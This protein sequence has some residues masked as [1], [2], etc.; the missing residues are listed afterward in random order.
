MKEMKTLTINNKSYVITDSGAI[1]FD[2]EQSLTIEQQAQARE[3]IG[4]AGIGEGGVVDAGAV[5]YTEQ[6]L[7]ESQQAQARKNIGAASY[8]DVSP[9]A[10][11][12]QVRQAVAVVDGSFIRFDDVF[13]AVENSE[14]SV[15]GQCK[16]IYGLEAHT[17]TS[18]T[19][20]V[21]KSV[22]GEHWTEHASLSI[23]ASNGVW[24]TNLFVDTFKN[25]LILLKTTDG[26]DMK[27]N[28]VCT[29]VYNGTSWYNNPANDVALG[30]KRWLSNNCS[31]DAA[32]NADWSERA[33][34]FGEYGTTED[35]TTYSLWKITIPNITNGTGWKKVLELGGNKDN[36]GFTGEIRHWHTVRFDPYSKHW[37]A[38][39]GD[40]DSQCRMYR[41]TDHG[42]TWDL[43]FSGSQ[44]ERTTGFVFEQDCIYYGMDSTNNTDL[45]S[46]KI[47]KIDRSKL[48]TD[49]ENCRTDVATVDSAFAIRGLSRTY[50]PDGFIVFTMQEPNAS[51]T[52]GRYILQFFD[53]ATQKLYPIAYFDTSNMSN[54][55][56]IGFYESAR[57]QH[58]PSGAIYA[59]PSRQLHQA[60]YGDSYVSTHIKI[61]LT[62]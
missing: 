3:N 15:A 8:D 29:F 37:W 40:G 21:F 24:F 1:R 41:S 5:L 25:I 30:K 28:R 36:A 27:N 51:F 43:I 49:R 54:S 11:R 45:D 4:A 9:V 13:A 57:V 60:K 56:N 42:E 2:G 46:I 33:I 52:P 58:T 6:T 55:E 17:K 16:Q 23:D 35:G 39:T 48:D 47:V 44:R 31:I 20:R 53:Y 50:Y 32:T 26:F 7:A 61:N 14:S 12:A 18:T 38:T 10:P 19:Q 62:M 59:M 34:I 22:D